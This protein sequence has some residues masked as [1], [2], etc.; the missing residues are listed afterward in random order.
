MTCRVDTAGKHIN[1]QYGY[2]QEACV[3]SI[4][5]ERLA[6]GEGGS[7]TEMYKK[8]VKALYVGDNNS[9]SST[10][11]VRLEG[12]P[13]PYLPLFPVDYDEELNLEDPG[14]I[15]PDSTVN[16]RHNQTI[17]NSD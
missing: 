17:W 2:C 10:R 7:K 9:S 14:R 16:E 3:A 4:D 15:I 6:Q 1:G 5:M 13:L 12:H 8:L 11:L